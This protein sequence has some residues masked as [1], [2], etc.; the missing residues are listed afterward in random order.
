MVLRPT[1]AAPGV[2][3]EP[4]GERTAVRWSRQVPRE[5]LKGKL[6]VGG[7]VAR[8]GDVTCSGAVVRG[9]A[10]GRGGDG[11][12]AVA[13]AKGPSAKAAAEAPAGAKETSELAL[14][15]SERLKAAKSTAEGKASGA[16]ASLSLPR[17]P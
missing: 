3:P 5:R 11:A 9:E 16:A 4:V 17:S 7:A 12:V 10:V 2:E 6:G 14:V 1:R 8:K 13:E 15:A